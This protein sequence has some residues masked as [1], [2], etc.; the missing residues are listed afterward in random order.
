[1]DPETIAYE[2]YSISPFVELDGSL[3]SNNTVLTLTPYSDLSYGTEY[4]ITLTSNIMDL[5]KRPL[6][7]TTIAFTT[8]LDEA[9]SMISLHGLPVPVVVGAA[10]GALLSMLAVLVYVCG[11]LSAWRLSRSPPRKM[12]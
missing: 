6:N 12:A 5:E 1:V 8:S 9:R 11:S 2:K 3:S 10:S 7:E 4:T